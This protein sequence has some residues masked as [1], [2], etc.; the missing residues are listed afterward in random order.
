[1]VGELGIAVFKH[2]E[3]ES[4]LQKM[5]CY[6]NKLYALSLNVK[7]EIY[8]NQVYMYNEI[9]GWLLPAVRGRRPFFLCMLPFTSTKPLTYMIKLS[10]IFYPPI[11]MQSR[12]ILIVALT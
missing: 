8:S 10:Y 12:L 6:S 4:N 1:M 5:N 9:Q 7:N 11:E 3:F 2:V